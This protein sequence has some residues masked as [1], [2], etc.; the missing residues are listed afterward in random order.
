[1]APALQLAEAE[2]FDA[3][4]VD[5]NIRGAKSFAVLKI[6]EARGI[7]FLLSSGYADWSMP[8]EWADRPRLA[9]PY[10]SDTLRMKLAEMLHPE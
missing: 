3:A 5:I 2:E 10:T 1:M 8:E 4:I 9:K 6:L 7:P